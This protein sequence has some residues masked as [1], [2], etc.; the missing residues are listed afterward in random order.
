MDLLKE[1]ISRMI[2]ANG[3]GAEFQEMV[4][5][6]HANRKLNALLKAQQAALD[7]GRRLLPLCDVGSVDY[8]NAQAE[9]HQAFVA[10]DKLM[11]GA[12]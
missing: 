2:T 7:A 5:G 9:V 11:E 6:E 4:N 8:T 1:L 12:A 3:A 10:L